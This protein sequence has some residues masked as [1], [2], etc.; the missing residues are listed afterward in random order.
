MAYKEKETDRS[1]W[2]SS[3]AFELSTH[4]CHAATSFMRPAVGC[5]NSYLQ[6]SSATQHI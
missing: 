2:C 6:Q 1:A 5:G 4:S 3:C